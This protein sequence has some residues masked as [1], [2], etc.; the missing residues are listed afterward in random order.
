VFLGYFFKDSIKKKLLTCYLFK[1]LNILI[2][3]ALNAH[4]FIKFYYYFK[5]LKSA[6]KH[7]LPFHYF[8]R[9]LWSCFNIMTAIIHKPCHIDLL[10]QGGSFLSND[11]FSFFWVM[12]VIKCKASCPLALYVM[13]TGIDITYIWQTCNTRTIGIHLHIHFFWLLPF[14]YTWSIFL[15]D[16]WLNNFIYVFNPYQYIN[17][18]F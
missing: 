16:Y 18:S 6:L 11:H 13:D 15:L 4:I 2:F 17:F 3:N 5:L 9:L 12:I 10:G 14:T 1:T 7:L 8:F